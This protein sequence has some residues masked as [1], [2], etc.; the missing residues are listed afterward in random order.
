MM[1]LYLLTVYVLALNV[2][3]LGRDFAAL[4]RGG[5]EMPALAQAVFQSE[6]AC[7]KG[8]AA[9]YILVNLVLLYM[10]MICNYFLT[11][12]TL[13]GPLWYGTLSAVMFMANPVHSEAVLNLSGVVDLL[14]GLLGLSTVALYAA[15]SRF[16]RW[17]S[18]CTC[19]GLS[20]V[21]TVA[22]PELAPLPLI[23]LAY[24]W[25]V[26][27]SWKKNYV[28][29]VPF[30]A[31]ATPSL[32]SVGRQL[33][34]NGFSLTELFRPL[35]FFVYPIGFKPETVIRWQESALGSA[36]GVIAITL[37]LAGLLRAVGR[38]EVTFGVLAMTL[39]RFGT[40][41]S[42]VEPYHMIGGGK[43][44]LANGLC[45]IA[46]QGIWQK[47]ATHPKWKAQVVV[48]TSFAAAAFMAIQ[49]NANI[50]WLNAGL[51]VRDFQASAEQA[52]ASGGASVIG[53]LPDFQYFDSAPMCL[54]ESVKYDTPFSRKVDCV[55]LAGLNHDGN[56]RAKF[57]VQREHNAALISISGLRLELVD[58]YPYRLRK[59]GDTMV[60]GSHTVSLLEQNVD[61]VTLR[62]QSENP[63]PEKLLSLQQLTYSG[64]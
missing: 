56:W 61:A 21:S 42:P 48:L 1:G 47:I 18:F 50:A 7:F 46:V 22:F 9:P 33:L 24:E 8:F 37:L 32:L 63:L 23:L 45:M 26:T 57:E 27:D 60:S 36:L 12:A 25:L 49:I 53:I 54:S 4:A 30:F 13:R 44:L 6:L 11:N 64:K 55:S 28:R 20:S 5:A 19:F 31:V 38:R 58:R 15:H 29:L 52:A 43:L 14:P 34:A 62:V 3:P 17:W 40:V 51:K 10:C 59:P 2:L 35:A 41:D 16:P 39:A